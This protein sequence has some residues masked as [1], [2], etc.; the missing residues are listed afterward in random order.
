MTDITCGKYT[1]EVKNL[2]PIILLLRIAANT[3]AMPI[4]K[5]PEKNQILSK[6]I[7]EALNNG[8]A[9]KSV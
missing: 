2:F 5:I 6:F 1:I 8:L 4:V 7:A 3:N 9:N